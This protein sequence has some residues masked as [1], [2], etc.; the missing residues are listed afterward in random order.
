VRGKSVTSV[1][2]LA[3][4]AVAGCAS[5]PARDPARD[6]A[7]LS[8]DAARRN[9]QVATY[10]PAELDQAAATLR[11]ADGL[12]SSGGR[13]DAVHQLAVLARQRAVASQDV[14]RL[15][16]EQAA[17]VCA[18]DSNRCAHS[19]RHDPRQAEVAQV[20]AAAFCPHCLRSRRIGDSTGTKQATYGPDVE[21]VRFRSVVFVC[22]FTG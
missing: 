12:A 15:C 17:L 8:L 13:Y 18:A 6:D 22:G 4:L 14:A 3:I 1:V 7:R 16:S 20:Q 11:Q 19:G 10:A 2:A 9:A 5:F 21:A